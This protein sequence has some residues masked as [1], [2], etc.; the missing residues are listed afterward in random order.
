MTHYTCNA[1]HRYVFFHSNL[2]FLEFYID[3]TKNSSSNE[4]SHS[5]LALDLD[6]SRILNIVWFCIYALPLLLT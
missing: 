2:Y 1:D 3:S 6:H 5:D 4:I